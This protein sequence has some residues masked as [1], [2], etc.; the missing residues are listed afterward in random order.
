MN[1]YI[2][3]TEGSQTNDL[4]LHVKLLEKLEQAKPKTSRRRE[5]RRNQRNRDQKTLHRIN[6][7]QSYKAGSLK[8]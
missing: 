4:M 3:N 6:K 8:K 5:I 1:A 7:T 2:K